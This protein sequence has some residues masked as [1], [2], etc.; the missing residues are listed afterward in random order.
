MI[1]EKTYKKLISDDSEYK[2]LIERYSEPHRYYHTLKHIEDCLQKLAEVEHLC[3]DLK[4]LQLAIFYHDFIYFPKR[5]DNEEKSAE[6]AYKLLQS[7][8]EK[9]AAKVRD[10]ILLT[11]HPSSPV[12]GDEHLL[13]DIDLSI[14]G[15]NEEEY[16]SYEENIRKEFIHV[17]KLL[18]K[19]G[20]SKLLKKFL[21][22]K[23][24]YH[25]DYFNS[26]YETQARINLE[27]ALKNLS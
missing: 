12:T 18:Y 20:R 13:L 15:A 24:I 11:R 21:K 3:D 8:S 26:R 1:I 10:L 9:T 4:S 25:S 17:P 22:Q 5:K 23:R 2:L 27:K 16:Q 6:H 7:N 14:L 19:I